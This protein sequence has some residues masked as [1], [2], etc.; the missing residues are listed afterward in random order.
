MS[1]NS[2]LAKNTVVLAIGTF[3]PKLASF[4]TL[5]L[6]T[7][8]LSKEEYGTYDL[9]IVLVSLLLPAATLQISSAAFRF[10]VEVREDV[11]QVKRIVTN[12]YAVILPMSAITLTGLFIFFN[13]TG[14]WIKI[15]ICCYFLFDV[16]VGAARQVA[17][18]LGKNMVFSICSI[19]SAIG[20]LLFTL[21]F[22]WFLKMRLLGA[23][24]S[25]V[26]AC[27]FSLV[28]I[29]L[30]LKLYRYIDVKLIS[31]ESIMELL[32]YSWPLVPNALSEWVMRV[33]DRFVVTYF[34]G[35]T[36]NAVYS[37][38]NK[39][40]SLLSLAQ[41]TFTMAWQENASMVSKDDDADKYYSSMFQ[42]MFDLIAGFFGVLM[43]VT[44]L[45][46]I[47]LIK[48]D[49]DDAYNHIPILFMGIFFY[50]LSAFLGGIY[51]AYKKTLSVG[52]T[53][54]IAAILN[55]VIDLALINWIG[56]YA[57]SVSTLASHLFLFVF[58]IIDVRKL[59]KIK[60]SVRHLVIVL[61]LIIMECFLCFQRSF[62]L[63]IAN[64][65]ISTAAFFLLNHSFV[66]SVWK[67]MKSILAKRR[68]K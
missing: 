8:Y 29:V 16:L 68:S 25:L 64:F 23:V 9:I 60:F 5:P 49:Y 26:A 51:S 66:K 19:M 50:S 52:V 40:P 54:M 32:G 67:K 20:K 6:L 24:I 48:G 28:Y 43:A 22:V 56:L 36:A 47:L 46:F 57:A 55:L 53:T 38:A 3:L 65:I 12:I 10:L 30:S 7:G 14:T 2:R 1:R 58:R 44:P 34:M 41:S 63:D 15:W 45:L 62:W 18:G 33:S 42:T 13:E 59:V 35:L 4:I 21:V 39:I 11:Q 17:R 27:L 37:V 61:L 31:K